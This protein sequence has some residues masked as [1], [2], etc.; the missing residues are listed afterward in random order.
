MSERRVLT[1]DGSAGGTR[2][3]RKPRPWLVDRIRRRLWR[4]R[5]EP[6]CVHVVGLLMLI[7][8]I[9]TKCFS[10]LKELIWVLLGRT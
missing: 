6:W 8:E 10:L 3:A 9:E 7:A 5:I 2:A 1:S 4:V